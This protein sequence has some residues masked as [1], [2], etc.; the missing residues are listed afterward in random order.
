M[1]S[2]AYDE[3]PISSIRNVIIIT[4]MLFLIKKPPISI[5][6]YII[7][8]NIIN[9]LISFYD[10]ISGYNNFRLPNH[11]QY[12]PA[13]SLEAILALCCQFLVMSCFRVGVDHMEHGLPVFLG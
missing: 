12:H 9:I 1:T 6:D 3:M 13:N 2:S 4:I 5:I 7:N 11:L 10:L 8:V